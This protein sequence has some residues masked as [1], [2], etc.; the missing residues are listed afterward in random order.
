MWRGRIAPFKHSLNIYIKIVKQH[1]PKRR[2]F[3][4]IN[5]LVFVVLT[6]KI[7]KGGEKRHHHQRIPSVGGNSDSRRLLMVSDAWRLSLPTADC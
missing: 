1:A 5:V 7:R 2:P 6:I 4:S 3:E